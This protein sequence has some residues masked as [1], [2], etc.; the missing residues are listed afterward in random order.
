MENFIIQ[1]A[2]LAVFFAAGDR[3]QTQHARAVLAAIAL[4]LKQQLDTARPLCLDQAIT[5][6]LVMRKATRPK[7]HRCRCL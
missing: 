4:W 5:L 3:L 2:E 6:A 1:R 7:R